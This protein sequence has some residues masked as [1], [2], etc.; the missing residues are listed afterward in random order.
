MKHRAG[1]AQ[2]SETPPESAPKARVSSDRP[3]GSRKRRR[4]RSKRFSKIISV[5]TAITA[6]LGVA[7]AIVAWLRPDPLSAEKKDEETTAEEI[8]AE[9]TGS[10][11]ITA[12]EI[13]AEAISIDLEDGA[14]VAR[15]A[16]LGGTAPQMEDA[17][18]W[19]V[20]ELSGGRLVYRP[21]DR[22]VG[23][24][25]QTNVTIGAASDAD[26]VFVVKALYFSNAVSEL[27]EDG[28]DNDDAYAKELPPHEG[29]VASTS[30]RRDEFSTAPCP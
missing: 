9:E 18:L 7:V 25:W 23:N 4:K 5:V 16:E 29:E 1:P 30:V 13:A 12:E 10:E 28:L 19:V 24:E 11:D 8:A 21:V 26:L 22:H 15:C 27:L 3:G 17:Q 20:I 2:Q 14:V 6:L